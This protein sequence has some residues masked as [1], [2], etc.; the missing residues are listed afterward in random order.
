M[1]LESSILIRRSPE[2][3]WAFLGNLK[4]VPKWD[5]GVGDVRQTSQ[6]APGVGTEFQ[7]LG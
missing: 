4:N 7:T 2:E 6:G 5:Q 3:V 1:R